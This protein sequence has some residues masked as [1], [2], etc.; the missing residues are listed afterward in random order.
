MW[1]RYPHSI[2]KHLSCPLQI[3]LN[4]HTGIEYCLFGEEERLCPEHMEA[5]HIWTRTLI[6]VQLREKRQVLFACIFRM[7]DEFV[8]FRPKRQ[9]NHY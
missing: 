9:F 8:L 5:K 4:E 2:Q 6:D 1:L 3:M 7:R